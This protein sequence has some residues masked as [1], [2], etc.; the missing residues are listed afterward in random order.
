MNEA[1]NYITIRARR[2]DRST[3]LW[4]MGAIEKD[5]LYRGLSLNPYGLFIVKPH[6]DLR[7]LPSS[8]RH[9]WSG[10]GHRIKNW[11]QQKSIAFG[12]KKENKSKVLDFPKR[13]YPSF[14][15]LDQARVTTRRSL[16]V[17]CLIRGRAASQKQQVTE[18]LFSLSIIII[19]INKDYISNQIM[20]LWSPSW[21]SFLSFFPRS[22]TRCPSL[23]ACRI[24]S[25]QRRWAPSTRTILSL[26][27]E[28]SNS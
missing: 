18:P 3:S 4:E 6:M 12:L 20:K 17:F 15:D 7:N 26:V 21:S 5:L 24:Q 25:W 16:S 14:D 23:R 22:N 11:R 1:V 2:T 10:T 8:I 28:H 19:R 9:T 27:T 13:L